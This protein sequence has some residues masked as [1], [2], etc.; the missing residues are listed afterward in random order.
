[1]PRL[2]DALSPRLHLARLKALVI[3]LLVAASI[4]LA[5]GGLVANRVLARVQT[6]A[7]SEQG[8]VLRHLS[9]DLR[10]VEDGEVLLSGKLSGPGVL[11]AQIPTRAELDLRLTAVPERLD[12]T[13][14][15]NKRVKKQVSALARITRFSTGEAQ[16]AE[17]DIAIHARFAVKVQGRILKRA[18]QS[19]Q[20]RITARATPEARDGRLALRLG[21]KQLEI[22]DF[23]LPGLLSEAKSRAKKR[24]DRWL[25]PR[26]RLPEGWRVVQAKIESG[27]LVLRLSYQHDSRPWY[28]PLDGTS[29]RLAC[30][31]LKLVA[32]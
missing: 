15:L 18:E 19:W 31:L 22:E 29:G 7:A 20:A 17:K 24:L 10:L 8:Y 11:R 14:L 26:L 25:Y 1:M 30:G 27:T 4:A 2:P 16:F 12:L 23:L 28:C 21:L 32:A 6:A 9:R 13:A 5:L 3:S